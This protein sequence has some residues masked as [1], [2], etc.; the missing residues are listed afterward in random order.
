MDAEGKAFGRLTHEPPRR[1][2]ALDGVDLGVAPGEVLG[3][4][5]TTA[6][7]RRP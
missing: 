6:P 3:L 7:G 4:M 5:G 1:V 2:L